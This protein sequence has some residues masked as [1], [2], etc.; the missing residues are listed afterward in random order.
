M[1]NIRGWARSMA[2]AK[3][4]KCALSSYGLTFDKPGSYI[5]VDKLNPF[6]YAEVIVE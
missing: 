2:R 4:K 6:M 5:Y 3:D 1:A